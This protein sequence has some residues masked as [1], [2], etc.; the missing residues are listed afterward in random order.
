MMAKVPVRITRWMVMM[1]VM[2]SA[3]RPP[4]PNFFC[5]QYPTI[6][7]RRRQIPPQPQNRLRSPHLRHLGRQAV[8]EG[9]GAI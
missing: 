3:R 8:A 9:I 6:P 7:H 2:T 5:F 4:V 1:L